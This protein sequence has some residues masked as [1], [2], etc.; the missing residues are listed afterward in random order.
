MLY[1]SDSGDLK[2]NEGA[3]YRITP[4]GKVDTVVDKKM[5]PELQGPNGLVLDGASYL[6]MVDFASGEI[7]RIKLADR[8]HEKI[9]DGFDGGD[10]LAWD[11]YGRLFITT[12]KQGKVWAIA[13]PGDAP[14]LLAEGFESAADLC[15]SPDG[16]SFSSPT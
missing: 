15:F 14:M 4:K 2:G 10:G 7:H 8:T 5:W 6:L 1:V 16:K 12:W 11:H 3:V 9:A 13:R